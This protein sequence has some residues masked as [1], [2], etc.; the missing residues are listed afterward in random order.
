MKSPQEFIEE[1]SN[2]CKKYNVEI[3]IPAF[4]NEYDV[5]DDTSMSFDFNEVTKLIATPYQAEIAVKE[6]KEY[7]F[8]RELEPALSL[9]A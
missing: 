4:G 8:L 7:N 2:I 1:L 5:F 9:S 6:T 3:Y